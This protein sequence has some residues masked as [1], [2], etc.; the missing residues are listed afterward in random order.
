MGWER[1]RNNVIVLISDASTHA[2][3]R[4]DALKTAERFH[5]RL[6]GTI[7]VIDAEPT[8]SSVLADLGNVAVAGGG[9]AYRIEDEG[10]F[11]EDLVVSVFP[12]RFRLDVE[13]IVK[14][15]VEGEG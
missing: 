2:N 10:R 7:N 15:Y 4:R 6:G 3:G 1:G 8:R 13:E 14:R 9:S 12:E 11:W 5:E